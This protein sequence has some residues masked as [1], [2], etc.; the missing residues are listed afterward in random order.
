MTGTFRKN[1][2]GWQF[3]A[4]GEKKSALFGQ[5]PGSAHGGYFERG[6]LFAQHHQAPGEFLAEIAKTVFK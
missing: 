6:G 1:P 2:C 3:G 4:S 5:P